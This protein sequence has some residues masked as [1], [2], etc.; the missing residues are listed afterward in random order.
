VPHGLK[1][2]P[3]AP[4]P[5]AVLDPI[6]PGLR[7][8][9]DSFEGRKAGPRTCPPS[10]PAD[11]L[12]VMSRRSIGATGPR[13]RASYVG[14]GVVVSG[15][16][17][18]LAACGPKVENTP[19]LDAETPSRDRVADAWAT[20]MLDDRGREE[21]RGAMRLA[22]GDRTSADVGPGPVQNPAGRW[23][24]LPNAVAAAA[25]PLGVAIVATRFDPPDADIEEAVAVE[26]D[27]LTLAN[28]PGRL[29]VE[30]R[31]APEI[32][33]ATAEIGLFRQRE[34]TASRFIESI[35]R[36]LRLWGRKPELAPLAGEP[37]S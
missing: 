33:V 36:Q 9:S 21:V 19:A 1:G 24:D 13:P 23:K 5:T 25:G 20:R 26:F 34:E 4:V 30:R 10:R 14:R 22:A 32:Y 3:D 31:D 29:R 17:L 11:T 16:G 8:E 12:P 2:L 27:L 6:P 35:G 37:P 18:V 28:E 15:L 7:P